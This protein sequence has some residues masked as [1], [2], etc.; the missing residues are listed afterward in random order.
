MPSFRIIEYPA[1]LA[2]ASGNEKLQA[3][4]LVEIRPI[5]CGNA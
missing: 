1:A 3:S 5:C 2:K 4:H